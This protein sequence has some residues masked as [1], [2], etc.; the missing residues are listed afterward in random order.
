MW[1]KAMKRLI[2]AVLVICLLF[3]GCGVI[4]DTKGAGDDVPTTE[5]D[6]S[7]LDAEGST[8]KAAIYF[9]NS[10]NGTLTADPRFIT[11]EQNTNP[12]RRA[13]Q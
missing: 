6:L 7:S 11:V 10:A 12:A 4:H 3:T 9:L 8:K 1:G 5:L 13:D 2:L